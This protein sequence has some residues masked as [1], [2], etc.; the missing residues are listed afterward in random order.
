MRRLV[1]PVTNHEIE[2]DANKRP[3]G[4]SKDAQRF[5]LGA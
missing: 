3:N 2:C 4:D 5:L 1:H